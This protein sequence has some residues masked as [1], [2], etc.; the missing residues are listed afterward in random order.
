MC[1]LT[2]FNN[3]YKKLIWILLFIIS[4]YFWL[5]FGWGIYS[6]YSTFLESGGGSFNNFISSIF[7]L[8]I[9]DGSGL[10]LLIVAV[11]SVFLLMGWMKYPFIFKLYGVVSLLFLYGT[12]TLLFCGMIMLS[13][14][15]EPNT[16][17]LNT[18]SIAKIDIIYSN[19]SDPLNSISILPSFQFENSN[20]SKIN[21]STPVNPQDE[22]I[23]KLGSGTFGNGI[24]IIGI[25]LA[26]F[27]LVISYF[28]KIGNFDATELERSSKNIVK[29]GMVWIIGF[30]IVVGILFIH[31]K[32]IAFLP[33]Y[34]PLTLTVYGFLIETIGLLSIIYGF[35]FYKRPLPE[36]IRIARD[37]IRKD[38]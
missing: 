3:D 5:F 20:I 25:A 22:A 13:L 16:V 7:L 8:S 1:R 12:L 17:F 10:Y 37:Q 26:L 6:G 27:G 24:G 9:I 36:I 11:I 21:L 30:L 29:F 28:E 14:P 18:T 23:R 35:C 19:S 15:S 31:I 33:H 38:E 32:I 4:I 34:L 2:E